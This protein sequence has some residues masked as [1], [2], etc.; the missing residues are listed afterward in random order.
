MKPFLGG[1]AV[2]V[3]MAGSVLAGGQKVEGHLVD[4][5]CAAENAQKPKP[6]FAAKHSKGCLEMAECAASGYAIVT[7]DDKVIKLDAKG[8]ETATKL[9]AE[10]TKK[11]DFKASASGKL[12]GE[13]L[14]V[15]SLTLQ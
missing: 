13:T 1:V 12:D 8:N 5:A 9:I 4:V 10:S 11:N 15:E 3:L 14:A 7:A 2:A 6:G